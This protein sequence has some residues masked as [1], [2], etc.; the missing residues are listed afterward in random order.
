MSQSTSVLGPKPGS[1]RK[2]RTIKVLV[3]DLDDT[4][5]EGTLLEGDDL[6]LRSGVR[7]VLEELDRRGI[8]NSIASKNEH[9]DAMAKLAEFGLDHFFLYPQINWNPKSSGIGR[10]REEL[11]VG[12]DAVAFI[13][14]QPFE[15]DEVGRAHSEVLQL[16]ASQLTQIPEMP[17][18]VPRFITDESSRRRL[19]Y[20]ADSRRKVAE[21]DFEGTDE[22]FLASLGMSFTIS[23]VR[24]EDLERAEELTVRT[25]QLNATGES[26]SYEQLDGLRHSSDHQLL[27][28]E[29]SDRYGD[30]GK[31]GLA[32]IEMGDE[33]WTIKLLLMS[34]RVMSRGVGTILVNHLMQGAK[35]SG[36]RLLAEFKNTGRNRM[37]LIAFKFAGFREVAK[38]GE[39][40][41]LESDLARIQPFP[42]YVSVTIA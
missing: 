39:I 2:Q 30:Y 17:E 1:D 20:Q 4:V 22:E 6:R 41:I 11:N 31:I 32:L 5:W 10:I 16:Q 26:Y 40:S 27:I 13:D 19:L 18:F 14:D 24:D 42:E 8:L 21:S 23:P 28:A 25:N 37:M 7:E 35:D 36:R 29:L 38:R 34:C 33:A 3:W 9:E 12:M 15:R